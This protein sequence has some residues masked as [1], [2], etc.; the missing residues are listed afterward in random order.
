M[1]NNTPTYWDA[2]GTSL[3]TFA[4]S[5]STLSGLGPPKPRGND[6]T[7]AYAPGETFRKKVMGSN[8]LTLAMWLRG[9][10]EGDYDGNPSQATYQSNYQDLIRL[11]WSPSAMGKQVA[12]TKRF[13]D[14]GVLRS[15]K[16][17]VEYQ[18]GL[19]PVMSGRALSRCTVDLKLADPYFYNT[20]LQSDN[21]ST[22]DNNVN[23]LG[24]AP[25]LASFITINGAR[26]NTTVWNK[27][28]GVQFTHPRAVSAGQN[29]Y[30]DNDNF[31]AVY[32]SGFL[33]TDAE[34]LHSGA[35]Q[36]MVLVPGLNVINVASSS[37][38]GTVVLQHRA[39]WT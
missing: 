24:T 11:L 18:G 8:V 16:A 14:G 4:R 19:A 34:I 17:M 15:A 7:V 35:P 38:S 29:I 27:T 12:L 10:P 32:S 25:T 5:I 36:W 39:A 28:S 33:A 6:E 31:T 1:P 2:D 30:I 9:I 22:G 26:T 37:G 20:V 21:L 3:H 23:V 13:Y